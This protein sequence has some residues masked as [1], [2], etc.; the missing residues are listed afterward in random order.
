MVTQQGIDWSDLDSAAEQLAGNWRQFGCFVWHRGYDLDNADNW[1]I[2]YTHHRDSGLLAQSNHDEIAKRLQPFMEADD[3]DVKCESHT[4]WAVGYVN[5]FSIRIHR[6]DGSITPA[7]AEFCQIKQDMEDYPILNESDYSDR[8]Y[9]A[10][11]ENYRSELWRLRNQLPKGWEAEVYSWF[12]D[13]GFIENRD[14]QGGWASEEQLIEALKK[15][16]LVSVDAHG[17]KR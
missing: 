9:E 10:T 2:F 4:H 1:M 15:L 7:F 16:G 12:S 8:E 11:L 14:D 5:G 13:N 6:P 17:F 3:P